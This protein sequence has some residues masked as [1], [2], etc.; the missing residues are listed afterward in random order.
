MDTAAVVEDNIAVD[1][2]EKP[3]TN[4]GGSV[5]A[6]GPTG[7][8]HRV[9]GTSVESTPTY[10]HAVLML[11]LRSDQQERPVLHSINSPYDVPDIQERTP[12]LYFGGVDIPP[13]EGGKP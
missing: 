2:G 1:A 6:C 12:L 3:W 9:M 13:V 10:A 7:N 5:H 11:N 4:G 8:H